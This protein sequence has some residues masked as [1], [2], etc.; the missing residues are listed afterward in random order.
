MKRLLTLFTILILFAC[1]NDKPI[2]GNN[3]KQ[4]EVL[5]KYFKINSPT[6]LSRLACNSAIDFEIESLDALYNIDSTQLFLNGKYID[7]YFTNKLGFKISSNKVGYNK[8]K[9]KVFIN[10]SLIQ[11]EVKDIFLL[12]DLQPKELEFEL[13]KTYPH[14]TEH[15]TEGFVYKDGLLYEGTGN[16]GESEIFI[17]E[18]K[19]GK[20]INSVFNPLHVFGE[21]IAIMNNKITQL[22][23]KS[24]EGYIYNQKTL[25]KERT[26][27]YSFYTDGWGL[28]NDEKSFYMSNGTDNIFVLEAENYTV[29]REIRVC[30][31]IESIKNLNELEYVNGLIYSNIWMTNKIAQ[32]DPKSG[33]V[34]GYLD[35]TSIIPQKYR[36]ENDDV[37]NGIAYKSSN[38]NLLITGKRWDK[39]YEIKI[40]ED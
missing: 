8:L 2:E 9:F 26:F 39:I 17:T 14:S 7:T 3:F 4:A 34:L 37:L 15:Y 27:K 38:G 10:D 33:K 32:I 28:T 21:G 35:L 20:I 23:Y 31:N 25:E 13:V 36:N 16:W 5:K 24:M 12:S 22:T 19:T 40:I 11:T 18:L 29:L 6:N 1:N 30:D